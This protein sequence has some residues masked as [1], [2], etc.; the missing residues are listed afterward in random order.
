MNRGVAYS[1]VPSEEELDRSP[2][3]PSA[4]ALARGPLAVI[5]CV[6]K[7]PC[8]PCETVC[9]TGAISVGEP[10]TNLPRLDASRCTGCGLCIPACPGQAIFRVDI[11]HSTHEAT[12]SFP[13]EFLPVPA[14]RDRVVAVD[15]A[16]VPVCEALVLRVAM[17][18]AYDRTAV[19]TIVIP[20]EHAMRV[21]GIQRA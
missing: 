12:L 16:G 8:D 9:P 14:K 5:E 11:T 20:K 19:V 3:Y 13:Y 10:I 15:R 4:E 2:G 18:P 21:R 17:P 7:I 1:G 6:Q